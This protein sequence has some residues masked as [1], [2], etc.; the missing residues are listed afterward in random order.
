MEGADPLKFSGAVLKLCAVHSVGTRYRNVLHNGTSSMHPSRRTGDTQSRRARAK[1]RSQ[2]RRWSGQR[3][4]SRHIISS[5]CSVQ[6]PGR[7][8]ASRGEP[9]PLV[10]RAGQ[11]APSPPGCRWAA[12]R[13]G[14]P[15]LWA[16]AL[17]DLPYC[18]R[19]RSQ[20]TQGDLARKIARG[21]FRCQT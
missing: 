20:N 16:A 4:G 13:S 6:L 1:R 17:A 8:R 7:R 10:P 15:C 14:R 11:T 5:R 19:F 2:W 12:P 18:A 3:S 9:R 21:S